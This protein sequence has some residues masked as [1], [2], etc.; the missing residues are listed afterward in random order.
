MDFVKINKKSVEKNSDVD[1]I[2]LELKPLFPGE[3]LPIS[4]AFIRYYLK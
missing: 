1:M 4:N 3:K 2:E